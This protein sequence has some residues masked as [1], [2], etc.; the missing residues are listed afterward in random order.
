M[1]N[2]FCNGPFTS[3]TQRTFVALEFGSPMTP[4]MLTLA[5]EWEKILEIVRWWSVHV[6]WWAILWYAKVN[7]CKKELKQWILQ[8]P[9]LKWRH[10]KTKLKNNN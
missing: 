5:K 7:L 8:G 9:G 4:K 6:W 10:L 3:D 1:R 2:V